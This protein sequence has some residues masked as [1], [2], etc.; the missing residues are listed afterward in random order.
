MRLEAEMK[1]AHR[2]RANTVDFRLQQK[3]CC[4]ISSFQGGKVKGEVVGDE[5]GYQGLH[6]AFLLSCEELRDNS[7]Q[8]AIKHLDEARNN[9]LQF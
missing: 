6:A 9:L 2:E 3:G 5:H 4:V 7:S 8:R 1:V